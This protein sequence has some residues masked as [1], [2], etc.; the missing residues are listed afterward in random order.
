MASNWPLNVKEIL[1]NLN[2]GSY[3]SWRHNIWALA[4]LVPNMMSA[5]YLEEIVISPEELFSG[6]NPYFEVS[7]AGTSGD[8]YIIKPRPTVFHG[9]HIYVM[10]SVAEPP[11][12]IYSRFQATGLDRCLVKINHDTP[13]TTH[14]YHVNMLDYDGFPR[15]RIKTPSNTISRGE[16]D[17][18][19]T[20]FSMLIDVN[21]S[22][23]YY[24]SPS[25]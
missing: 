5:Q 7:G 4:Q 3:H 11:I 12:D 1:T 8:P 19:S 15:P 23:V 22:A 16:W 6:T 18:T 10:P 17:V 20:T 9:M 24:S 21:S 13:F 2:V 25:Y 14:D